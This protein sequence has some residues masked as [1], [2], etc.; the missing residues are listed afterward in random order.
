MGQN[1]ERSSKEGVDEM[2][3]VPW[4]PGPGSSDLR[5]MVNVKVPQAR[6]MNHEEEAGGFYFDRLCRKISL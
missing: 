1:S 2:K 4:E 5:I 6:I 3:G